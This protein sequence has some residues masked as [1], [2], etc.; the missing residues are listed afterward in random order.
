MAH[1]FFFYIT[2]RFITVSTWPATGPC[3]EPHESSP[4][5][6]IYFFISSWILSFCLAFPR[7]FSLVISGFRREIVERCALLGYYAASSGNFV[8]IFWN[9]LSVQESIRILD[10]WTRRMGRIGCPETSVRNYHYSLRN[11]PEEHVLRPEFCMYFC[12]I[13]HLPHCWCGHPSSI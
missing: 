10:S 7:W 11:N 2:W 13:P 6:G 8:P 1:S 4:H 3:L 9:N 5:P 12:Y